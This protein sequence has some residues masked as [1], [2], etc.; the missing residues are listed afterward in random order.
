MYPS[1]EFEDMRLAYRAA[2][3]SHDRA[4][5][6]SIVKGALSAGVSVRKVYGDLLISVLAEN[7]IVN[8]ESDIN[9]ALHPAVEEITL[10]QMETVR[11]FWP[12]K[13]NEKNVLGLKALV[14]P[15]PGDTRFLCTQAISDLLYMD[16]W[17]VTK[18]TRSVKVEEIFDLLGQEDHLPDLL[19][20]SVMDGRLNATLPLI[21]DTFLERQPKLKIY[22]AGL[23]ARL[24]P[25]LYE[26]MNVVY[27][28]GDSKSAAAK[29]HNLFAKNFNITLGEASL[30]SIGATIKTLRNNRRLSQAEIAELTGIDRT[31]LSQIENGKQ[32]ITLTA[33]ARIAEALEVSTRELIG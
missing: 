28:G 20:L 3:F 9:S 10:E 11:L 23:G 17:D 14:V 8:E 18:I 6:N 5:V 31:Y 12:G 13:K 21:A 30:K 16:G 24:S 32:N 2:L 27:W 25:S 29:L 4:G 1:I 15:I 22:V 26:N 33:L 7:I 19:A